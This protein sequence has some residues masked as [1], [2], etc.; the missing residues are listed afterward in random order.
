MEDEGEIGHAAT[1]KRQEARVS[2]CHAAPKRDVNGTL[3]DDDAGAEAVQALEKAL[4]AESMASRAADVYRH[5]D[6]DAASVPGLFSRE[7]DLDVE[8][9]HVSPG[10]G[11]RLSRKQVCN[12]RRE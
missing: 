10:R 8:L 5:P 11:A 2:V 1:A 7:R 6:A 3:V 4:A 9:S 12:Q